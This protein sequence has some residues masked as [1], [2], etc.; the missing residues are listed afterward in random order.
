MRS[1]RIDSITC[2]LGVSESGEVLLYQLIFGGTTN[3]CHPKTVPTTPLA[4]YT[5]TK[6][7]Y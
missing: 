2:T 4:Y 5:H 1:K 3:R 7:A 6:L